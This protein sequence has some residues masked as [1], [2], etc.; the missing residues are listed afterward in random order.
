MEKNISINQSLRTL[1][2]GLRSLSGIFYGG[3]MKEKKTFKIK[4]NNPTLYPH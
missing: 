4:N 1:G 3:F 2:I